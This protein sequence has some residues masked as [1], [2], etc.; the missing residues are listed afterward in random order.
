MARDEVDAL[1]EAWQRERPDLP[2]APLAVL[3]RV[4]RL[5]RLLDRARREA[6]A[7]HDLDLGDFDVL[8]ALRRSGNPYQLSA[9]A[10][11]ASTMV[12]SGTMTHRIDRLVVRGLV[13]RQPDPHDG[14]GVLVRLTAQGKQRVDAALASLLQQERELL[15]TVGEAEQQKLADLLRSLLISVEHD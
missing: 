9:G 7:E 5:A 4:T 11:G 2:V 8:A 6:F 12:T 15:A 1:I 13:E 3:S 14:R 10:L